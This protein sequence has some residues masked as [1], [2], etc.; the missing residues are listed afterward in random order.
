MINTSEY[1]KSSATLKIVNIGEREKS[2]KNHDMT[3]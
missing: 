2:E 3:R 1:T